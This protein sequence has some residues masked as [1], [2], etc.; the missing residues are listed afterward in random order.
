[1]ELSEGHGEYVNLLNFTLREKCPYSGFFWSVFPRIWTEYGKILH[2]SPYSVR[3]RENT[4]QKNSEYGH[5][6]RSVNCF[7]FFLV[8]NNFHQLGEDQRF[9]SGEQTS[10]IISFLFFCYSVILQIFIQEDEEHCC[11]DKLCIC[12]LSL[13]L[14]IF[15]FTNNGS[16]KSMTIV[17]KIYW[18]NANL[19]H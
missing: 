19:A 8:F 11:F 10:L 4:D 5:F 13:T 2:T 18:I 1:M 16:F 15:F 12:E 17:I 7:I 14:L 9:S 3:I 6:S